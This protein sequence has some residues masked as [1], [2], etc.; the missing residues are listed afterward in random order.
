MDQK[1]TLL[2]VDDENDIREIFSLIYADNFNILTA[3]SGQSAFEVYKNNSID[4][5]L[6]DLKMPNGDGAFLAQSVTE[7]IDKDPCP[8]FMMTANLEYNYEELLE[9]GVQVIFSKPFDFDQFLKVAEFYL[10]KIRNKEYTRKYHR[11]LCEMKINIE[12]AGKTEEGT[13]LDICPEGFL[14]KLPAHTEFIQKDILS[15]S[16]QDSTPNN[17]TCPI[18]GKA[19]CRWLIPHDDIIIAGFHILESE[20]FAQIIHC[21]NLHQIQKGDFN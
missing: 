21:Y 7:F 18:Q 15:F 2:I 5:I 1:R 9:R 16:T 17:L 11:A 20:K 10:S 13:I 4:I 6:T 19:E 14:A 3:D 8:I 12:V